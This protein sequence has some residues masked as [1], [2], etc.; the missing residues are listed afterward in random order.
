MTVNA[1]IVTRLLPA[2]RKMFPKLKIIIVED[3]L[4]SNAPHIQLLEELSFNYILVAKPSDHAYMFEKIKQNQEKARV[5]EM[6][7]QDED[8]T[9]RRYNYINN[10]PLNASHPELLVNFLEY[11][12]EKDGKSI[13]H[14]TWIT[15]IE[16]H[17]DNIYYVMKGGRARFQYENETFNLATKSRL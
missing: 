16:L 15:D 12:E 7:I 2:I 17:Q 5:R 11:W 10:I 4:A 13:Y 9:I 8:G 1:M 14:N 3:A 6:K